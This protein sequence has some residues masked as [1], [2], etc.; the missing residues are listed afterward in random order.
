[1]RPIADGHQLSR[2][3]RVTVAGTNTVRTTKV[4]SNIPTASPKPTDSMELP[5]G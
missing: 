4:S 2:P 5:P 1:L 3:K